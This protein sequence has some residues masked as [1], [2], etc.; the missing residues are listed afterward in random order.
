MIKLLKILR[1]IG[2]EMWAVPTVLLVTFV[3]I[4]GIHTAE[5]KKLDGQVG[6]TCL[7]R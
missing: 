5:H 6:D 2:N 4:Q 7:N 3:L 1:A